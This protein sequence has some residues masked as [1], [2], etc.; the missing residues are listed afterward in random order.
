MNYCNLIP[1]PLQMDMTS[2]NGF[3]GSRSITVTGNAAFSGLMPLVMQ[4]MEQMGFTVCPSG[5][6]STIEFTLDTSVSQSEGYTMTVTADKISI[7]AAEKAGAF[8]ALQTLKQF[9]LSTQSD[10]IFPACSITDYPRFPWRGLMLDCSRNFFPV[11]FI[12][13]I[14]DAAALH[15]LNIFHWHLSDDQGWRLPVDKYPLLTEI[16]GWRFDNRS[17]AYFGKIG[18]V[19]TKDDIH[20]VVKYAAERCITVVPEIDMPGHMSSLLAAYPGFGCTGGPYRVED[21][22]GIFDDVLCMGNPELFTLIEGIFDAV[23]SLFPARYVHIGGDECP[24]VR[25]E[26]CP[27]CRKKMEELGIDSAGKLQPWFV[28]K[29]ATML[30]HRGKIPIGWDEVLD[31]AEHLPG[32][33]IV[34]SW[35]GIEG[36]QKGAASGHKVIMSPSTNGCYLDYRTYADPMEMGRQYA[37]ATVKDSYDFSVIPA[38]M[39]AEDAAFIIGGQGNLWTEEIYYGKIAEYLLFPRLSALAEALWLP[40]D[41]KDFASFAARLPEHKQ[42]LRK[43]GLLFYDGALE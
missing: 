31:D 41:K 18:G 12:C 22:F 34:Q 9:A 15:K 24:R 43:M 4:E 38:G 19:Y 35:R 39:S 2:G 33:L 20:T 14:L 32:S 6:D 40:Q 37:T 30:E 10:I 1:R 21:R 17:S 7:R 27:K 28:S 23:T 25:W 36:G 5:A 13:K 3:K 29:L 11:S 42:R 8:Y 16:G 26:K